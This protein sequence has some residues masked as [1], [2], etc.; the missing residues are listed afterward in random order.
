MSWFLNFIQ[1]CSPFYENETFNEFCIEFHMILFFYVNVFLF[2][3]VALE[4]E[5]LQPNTML[6]KGRYN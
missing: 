6:L 2:N 1:Q 3:Y 5:H 4:Y